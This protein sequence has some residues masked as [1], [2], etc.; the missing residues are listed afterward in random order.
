MLAWTAPEHVGG[1]DSPY[2]DITHRALAVLE[3]IVLEEFSNATS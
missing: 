2:A 3:P 1:L